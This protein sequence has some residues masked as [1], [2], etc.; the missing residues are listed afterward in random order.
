MKFRMLEKIKY[1][2]DKRYKEKRIPLE[3]AKWFTNIDQNLD[4]T[5]VEAM[6]INYKEFASA[7]NKGVCGLLAYYIELGMNK[8]SME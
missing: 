1:E 6:N 4:Q 7:S 5:F 2:A 3:V 8:Q